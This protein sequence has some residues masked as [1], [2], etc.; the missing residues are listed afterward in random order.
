MSTKMFD[1]KAGGAATLALAICVVLLAASPGVGGRAAGAQ[2]QSTAA[3]EAPRRQEAS[4]QPNVGEIVEELK[5]MVEGID[6]KQFNRVRDE[7]LRRAFKRT[8]A[9]AMRFVGT[10]V[11][12]SRAAMLDEL[13]RMLTAQEQEVAR[14][15]FTH[16]DCT[17]AYGKCQNDCPGLFCGCRLQRIRCTW[18]ASKNY[19][20]Q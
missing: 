5:R 20:P 2:T 17:N 15:G 13:D 1:R 8:Y 12:Q 6:P 14:A 19:V 10:K 7:R 4:G 9:T 11:D 16:G 18:L 3:G